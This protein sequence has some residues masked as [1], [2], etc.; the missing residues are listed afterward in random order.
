[1]YIVDGVKRRENINVTLERVTSIVG[2]FHDAHNYFGL[3]KLA[4]SGSNIQYELVLKKQL[5]NNF[6]PHDQVW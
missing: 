3:I 2:P 5:L 1:M 6:N 4:N